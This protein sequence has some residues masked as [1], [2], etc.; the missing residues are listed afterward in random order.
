MDAGIE[1]VK[2]LRFKRSSLREF[3]FLSSGGIEPDR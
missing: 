1:P 2:L 3:S